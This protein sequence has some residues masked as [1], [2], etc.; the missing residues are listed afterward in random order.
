MTQLPGFERPM[1]DRYRAEFNALLEDLHLTPQ[2][3]YEIVDHWLT[4]SHLTPAAYV[5]FLRNVI[6]ITN[7]NLPGDAKAKEDLLGLQRRS[8]YAMA[9][10][11]RAWDNYDRAVIKAEE[12]GKERYSVPY[13]DIFV[14]GA[15]MASISD[16]EHYILALEKALGISVFSDAVKNYN[17]QFKQPVQL[18]STEAVIP[19]TSRTID[20]YCAMTVEEYLRGDKD[21]SQAI[22]FEEAGVFWRDVSGKY[23]RVFRIVPKDNKG[24]P[25]E[26]IYDI[27]YDAEKSVNLIKFITVGGDYVIY[28]K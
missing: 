10:L 16:Y 2:Q 12:S 17:E 28:L 9:R 21:K 24:A 14:F 5:R 27:F 19:S 6:V 3:I 11:A 7:P 20:G 22:A 13:P 15:A 26:V 25:G 1:H 18:S 4:D 8:T 23:I